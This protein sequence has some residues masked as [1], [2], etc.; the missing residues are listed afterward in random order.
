[1]EFNTPE[2]DNYE[3]SVLRPILDIISHN[4]NIAEIQG[5]VNLVHEV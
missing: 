1:M 5:G 4:G 2:R 3:L